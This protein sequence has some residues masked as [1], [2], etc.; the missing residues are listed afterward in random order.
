MR[1]V[2]KKQD[3]RRD[4]FWLKSKLHL[5]IHLSKKPRCAPIWHLSF[6]FFIE[7]LY[8]HDTTAQT[9]HSLSTYKKHLVFIKIVTKPLGAVR[10]FDEG[11]KPVCLVVWKCKK[12]RCLDKSNEGLLSHTDRT[13]W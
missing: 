9:R 1:K 11:W 6:D 12:K 10:V 3:A 4:L 13:R 5:S 2:R 8:V 7:K